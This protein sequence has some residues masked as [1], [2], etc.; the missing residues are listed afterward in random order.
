MVLIWAIIMNYKQCLL[1]TIKMFE[2]KSFEELEVYASA[3]EPYTET[4]T[5]EE[6]TYH[7]ELEIFK[8]DDDTIKCIGSIDDGGW[9]AFLPYSKGCEKTKDA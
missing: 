1:D 2:Q 4:V 9:R 6:K 5:I 3:G 8:V 7:I